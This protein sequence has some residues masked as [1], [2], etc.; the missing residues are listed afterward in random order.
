MKI[1]SPYSS[2]ERYQ[3]FPLEKLKKMEKNVGNV[4]AI[5]TNRGVAVVQVADIEKYNGVYICRIF[6]KLHVDLHEN[7][8]SYIQKKED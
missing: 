6:S 3:L 8:E 5:S 7:I 1:Y 4:Y 2:R